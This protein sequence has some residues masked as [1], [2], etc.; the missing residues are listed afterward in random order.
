M[1]EPCNPADHLATGRAGGDCRE[2]EAGAGAKQQ[3]ALDHVGRGEFSCRR[4]DA[5]GRPGGWSSDWLQL[6]HELRTP[7]NAIL[8]NVELLLDGSAGPLS[9]AGRACIADIQAASRQLMTQLQPLLLLV[10]ARTCP[11]PAA[12]LPLDVF[13]LLLRASADRGP[14]W[15]GAPP[16]IVPEGARLMVPGDPVWLGV[17]AASLVDLRAAARNAVGPISVELDSTVQWTSGVG[18][19]IFWTG[20]EPAMTSPLPLALVD[21]LLQLHEGRIRSLTEDGLSLDLP[22]ATVEPTRMPVG[23]DHR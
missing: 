3:P 21:A 23:R 16:H 22:T 4:P 7:L 18:L 8:G 13:E 1:L 9:S 20:F 12:K 6:S 5:D 19:R 14:G 17:L 10:Q 11:L 2:P 15:P